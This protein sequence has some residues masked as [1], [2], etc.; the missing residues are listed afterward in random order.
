MIPY[1]Y[2]PEIELDLEYIKQLVFKNLTRQGSEL[3]AYQR[4]VSDDPYMTSLLLQYPFMSDVY[5]I[6]EFSRYIPLPIHVDKNRNCALNIPVRNSETSSTVFY[7]ATKMVSATFNDNRIYDEIEAEFSE[8]FRFTMTRPVL[9]NTSIPHNVLTD[10][11]ESRVSLSWS[12]RPEYT[13]EQI[14]DLMSVR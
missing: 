12:V 5:N 3:L 4:L 6:Y 8:V 7:T 10:E 9:L 2:Y 13:F 11:R 1:I 14:V